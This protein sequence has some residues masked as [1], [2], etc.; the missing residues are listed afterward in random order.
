[1]TQGSQWRKNFLGPVL[2]P[3]KRAW[4]P[5][6]LVFHQEI[7]FIAIYGGLQD[8][9]WIERVGGQKRRG[10]KAHFFQKRAGFFQAHIL[11]F[12]IKGTTHDESFIL[13][14]N[15]EEATKSIIRIFFPTK[16]LRNYINIL[17]IFISVKT[18]NTA[19]WNILS[20]HV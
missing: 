7:D 9:C 20:Y 14:E 2:A 5:F 4:S 10:Q 1:M 3:R 12:C 13:F 16:C 18:I 17:K 19:K 6:S 11:T 8:R 15:F